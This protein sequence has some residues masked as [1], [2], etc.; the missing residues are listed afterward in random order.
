MTTVRLNAKRGSSQ[1]QATNSRMACAYVRRPLI[2]A[3][4]SNTLACA[5]SSSRRHP[6]GNAFRADRVSFQS[7]LRSPVVR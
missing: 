5:C 3:K 1:Y 7:R 4:V 6:A 2:D